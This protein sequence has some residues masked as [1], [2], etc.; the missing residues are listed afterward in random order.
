MNK[1][2]WGILF[3][4]I[5]SLTGILYILHERTKQNVQPVTNVFPPLNTPDPTPFNTPEQT[6][7]TAAPIDQLATNVTNPV[8]IAQATSIMQIFPVFTV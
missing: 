6:S 4:G 3:A 5:S 7:G 2:A 1:N 8:G